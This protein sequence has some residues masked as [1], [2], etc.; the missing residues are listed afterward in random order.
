MNISKYIDFYLLEKHS[1][2]KEKDYY[3]IAMRINDKDFPICFL[4]KDTYDL[5]SSKLK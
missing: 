2:R 3:C 5:L 4:S 1:S